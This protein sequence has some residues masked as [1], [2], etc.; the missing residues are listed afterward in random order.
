M[1]RFFVVIFKIVAIDIIL[2]LISVIVGNL[3]I[4]SEDNVL[5]HENG[6][7]PFISVAADLQ[8]NTH[9]CTSVVVTKFQRCVNIDL[10]LEGDV[11][12]FDQ[13]FL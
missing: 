9:R 13:Q 5:L 8:L 10:N 4:R 2:I 3:E 12:N 11:E 1:V 6:S 7:E